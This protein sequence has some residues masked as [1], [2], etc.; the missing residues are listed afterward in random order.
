MRRLVQIL[1]AIVFVGFGL[2]VAVTRVAP[3][4]DA[5]VRRMAAS[6]FQQT[7]A[8]LFA[9]DALRIVACGTASPVA[10]P[11][12]AGACVAVFA[13]GKFYV[14]DTGSGAW[15]NFA[16]WRIP[17]QHIGAV[18]YTHF[19]SDHITELGE[20]N[21]QTWGAGRPGPL[22]VFGPRG[23]EKLVAG[24]SEAYALDNTYRTAH[25]GD[26]VMNPAKG[27]MEAKPFEVDAKDPAGLVILEENGLVIRAFLVDHAP[28]A[29]AVGYRFD[30][31]GRSVAVS[32]DTVRSTSLIAASKGVDVL[33]HEAQANFLVNILQEEAAKAGSNQYS[34]ILGDIPTYHTSPEDAARIANEAGVELLVLYHLTP[35]PPNPVVERIFVRGVS[36]IRASGVVVARDGLLITLPAGSKEIDTGYV[37]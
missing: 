31:K 4:Q 5:I 20:F 23:V 22:R 19:H 28:I 35:P 29:P 24:Y 13:G 27:A 14:V 34:R 11:H 8:E 2:F 17:G 10:D 18:F 33:F 15:K 26:V 30:Y 25:H 21:L 12:R 9:E 3:L 16:L 1:V 32:G 37:D 36:D 7:R 6:V